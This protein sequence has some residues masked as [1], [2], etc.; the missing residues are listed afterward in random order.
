MLAAQSFML[1]LCVVSNDYKLEFEF[2][3]WSGVRTSDFFINTKYTTVS[4]VLVF[5]YS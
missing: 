4:I 2:F 5:E 3:W 1:S